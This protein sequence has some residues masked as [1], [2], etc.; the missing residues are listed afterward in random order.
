MMASSTSGLTRD[1]PG[2]VVLSLLGHRAR[3]QWP[4]LA[5]LLAIVFGGAML[6]GTCS[7]LVTR[8]AERAV[9]VAVSRAGPDDVEVTAFLGTIGGPDAQSVAADTRALVTAAL[10]PFA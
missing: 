10:T 9:E 1:R 3:A 6:L 7:L 2:S 5:A 8:T 4:V